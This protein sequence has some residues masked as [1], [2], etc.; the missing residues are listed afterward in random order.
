MVSSESLHELVYV[1]ASSELWTSA[2]LEDIL[3]VSKKRNIANNITGMLL[4]W[5]G[6]IIQALEGEK[7]EVQATFERISK[8]PRHK[9]VTLLHEHSITER[10]FKDWAMGVAR[11]SMEELANEMGVFTLSDKR[12]LHEHVTQN[13]HVAAKLLGSFAKRTTI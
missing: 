6:G 11:C 7:A 1:S 9:R 4:Y 10:T 12:A 3:V 2:T 8:D 13:T 5:E